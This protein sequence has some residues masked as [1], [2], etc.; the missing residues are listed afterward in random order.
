MEERRCKQFSVFG[1]LA[2]AVTEGGEEE[3]DGRVDLRG[4]EG[5]GRG[6]RHLHQELDLGVER[7]SGGVAC[8]L[9][10]SLARD[11]S[12]ENLTTDDEWWTWR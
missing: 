3:V 10:I 4:G 5:G 2:Q 6:A 11:F 1:L 9:L 12:D 7:S 8:Q